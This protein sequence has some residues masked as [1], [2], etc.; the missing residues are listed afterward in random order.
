M[1]IKKEYAEN[2]A[3]PKNETI[4]LNKRLFD[5]YN[6]IVDF[7]LNTKLFGTNIDLGSGDKGFSEVCRIN[8]IISYPYDYPEFDIEKDILSQSDE[9]VDFVTMNA[10]IEHIKDP[11]NILKEIKRVLKNEGLLFI[12]TPNWQLDFKNFY[13][14]PT[15]VKPYSPDTIKN[16]LKLAGFEVLFLEPGL[17]KKSTFWW[18]LPDKLKWKVASLIKG[19]TKSILAVGFK[20]NK[21]EKE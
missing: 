7:K 15:H 12:R 14:D 21:K 8:N 13:N 10:V 6:S 5:T 19:G 3:K 20:I 9:S 2:L 4:Y 17:I 18:K 16:T 11:S 1:D